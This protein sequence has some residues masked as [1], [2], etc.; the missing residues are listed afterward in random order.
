MH[1]EPFREDPDAGAWGSH[2]PRRCPV[3]VLVVDFVIVLVADRVTVIDSD[4]VSAL[5][6][7]RGLGFLAAQ[8]TR[9]P[10]AT[11]SSLLAAGSGPTGGATAVPGW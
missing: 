5:A 1:R 9:R 7:P 6:A 4:L 3:I 8:T 11:R 10:A 2:T